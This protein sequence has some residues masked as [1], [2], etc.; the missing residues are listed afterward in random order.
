MGSGLI[1]TAKPSGVGTGIVLYQFRALYTSTTGASV[2]TTIQ[3]FGTSNVCSSW[4]PAA[5][6][7]Y[8][9][10]VYAREPGATVAYQVSAWTTITA[11]DST[12]TGVTLTSNWPTAEPVGTA[13]TLTASPQGADG[14]PI[15]YQFRALYETATGTWVWTTIQDFSTSNV[16][17]NWTP[18][19]AGPYTVYVYA[20]QQG[21]TAA[22][23]VFAAMIVTAVD[24]TL[25]GVKLTSNWKTAQ[26]VGTALTLT[27]TPSGVGTGTIL[28]EFR[29]LSPAANGPV[30]TTIQDFSTSN[31]CTSWTPPT[32]GQ[33][34]IYVYAREQGATVLYQVYGATAVT[35]H[36][37]T[38]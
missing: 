9:V 24:A 23:Q 6:G 32:A 21:S 38:S 7:P 1:L 19:M 28:Y 14:V 37:S 34:T 11:V 29:S 33:Y 12:L 36:Y 26:L 27:A 22:Y 35:A 17:T 8:T 31:T 4:T 25:T 18:A 5:A 20:K 2:W 30:W 15:L 3:D 13:L 16:C 10:Y